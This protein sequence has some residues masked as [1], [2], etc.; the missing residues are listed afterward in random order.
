MQVFGQQGDKLFEKLPN[1]PAR[2]DRLIVV[3]DEV[4]IACFKPTQVAQQTVQGWFF[5]L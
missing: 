2:I 4:V 1:L 3:K 5:T